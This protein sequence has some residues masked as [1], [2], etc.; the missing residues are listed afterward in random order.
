MWQKSIPVIRL[1]LLVLF[2]LLLGLYVTD[3][4]YLV[5]SFVRFLCAS[6]LGLDI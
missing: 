6:C 2:A 4:Y 3:Q 1:A 5:R